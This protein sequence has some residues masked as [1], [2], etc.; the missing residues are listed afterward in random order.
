MEPIRRPP[1]GVPQFRR[2]AQ[3]PSCMPPLKAL[4]Q[5]GR[6]S[7]GKNPTPAPSSQHNDFGESGC[8]PW[9]FRTPVLSV[10]VKANPVNFGDADPGTISFDPDSSSPNLVRPCGEGPERALLNLLGPSEQRLGSCE[11]IVSENSTPEPRESGQVERPREP[12]PVGSA[13]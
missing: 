7:R 13:Q 4:V 12:G 9:N 6:P 10:N 11:T 8:R 1:P 5:P 2:S 3:R